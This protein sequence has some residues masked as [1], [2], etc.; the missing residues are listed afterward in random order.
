MRFR[1]NVL[2]IFVLLVF[3]LAPLFIHGQTLTFVAIPLEN[4]AFMFEEFLPF[5]D[6]L[7]QKTGLK[8]ELKIYSDYN[9]TLFHIKNGEVDLAYLSG[10]TFIKAHQQAGFHVLVEAQ[11]A[12]VPYYRSVIITR[13][14]SGID[15]LVQL[16]EHR[17]AFGSPYSTSNALF[18]EYLLFKAGIKLKDLHQ[19]RY[20][21]HHN[22]V[23]LSVLNGR[24]DAGGVRKS[25]ADQYKQFGL[26]YLAVSEE[27]PNFCIAYNP[28]LPSAIVKKLEQSLT[29]LHFQ[30]S[31]FDSFIPAEDAI[32][33]PILRIMKILGK[34]E[35]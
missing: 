14:D 24:F 23:V 30:N 12:N 10:T 27:I 17:F 22:Q 2:K 32:Y 13:K 21:K 11:R 29:T 31:Y 18:P 1:F 6:S 15:S 20:L 8:F 7:S 19:Y 35:N 5:L 9:E 25:I 33:D 4:P 16:K 26:K 3:W 28:K 34:Y